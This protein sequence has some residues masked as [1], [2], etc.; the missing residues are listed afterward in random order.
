MELGDK[1]VYLGSKD[2]P[3]LIGNLLGLCPNKATVNNKQ[4]VRKFI[5]IVL[6]FL[7]FQRTLKKNMDS[8]IY[9]INFVLYYK[10]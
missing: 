7:T 5:Q 4:V 3:I 9:I 10:K 1:Y 8:K 2:I 6:F